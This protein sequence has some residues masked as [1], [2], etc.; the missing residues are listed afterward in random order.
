MGVDKV[1]IH[2]FVSFPPHHHNHIHRNYA[3]QAAERY[4][5]TIP[6]REENNTGTER[7]DAVRRVVGG[8]AVA[9]LVAVF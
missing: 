9:I 5:A 3:D 1:G 4:D 2:K 8:I 6:M 7:D